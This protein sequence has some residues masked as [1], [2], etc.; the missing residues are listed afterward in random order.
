MRSGG[1]YVATALPMIHAR[2]TGPQK[3]LSLE[4]SRLSPMRK[5]SPRGTT[6]GS[7]VHTGSEDEVANGADAGR[8]LRMTCPS[9]IGM[10]SPGNPTRRLMYVSSARLAVGCEHERALAMP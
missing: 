7:R 4:L 1:Q 2:G 8:P 5:Y 9:R 3:R 6:I 10:R